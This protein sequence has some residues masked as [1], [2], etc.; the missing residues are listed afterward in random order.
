VHAGVVVGMIVKS[1]GPGDCRTCEDNDGVC[2]KPSTDDTRPFAADEKLC[3]CPVSRTGNFCEIARGL[4]I[5]HH[6][7]NS[8]LTVADFRQVLTLLSSTF[9]T[10][11]VKHNRS[12]NH[13]CYSAL[14]TAVKP[15]VR[16]R[17]K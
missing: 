15:I 5:N 17:L 12:H 1:R 7:I 13:K 3:D 4:R 10:L 9:L 6:L 14:S 2:Y 11:A 16:S 8:T